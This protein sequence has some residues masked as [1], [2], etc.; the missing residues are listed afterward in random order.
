MAKSLLGAVVF[1]IGVAAPAAADEPL[2]IAY[3]ERPPLYQ[4]EAG[5]PSGTLVNLVVRVLRRAAIDAR[6]EALPSNRIVALVQSG[7][8]PICSPGWFKTPERMAFARFTLPIHRGQASVLLVRKGAAAAIAVH[9]SFAAASSDLRL[10]LGIVDRFS[11][12]RYIDERILGKQANVTAVTGTQAQLA[13][14][15]AA[16]RMDYMIVDPHEIAYLMREAA[17]E[18][19]GLRT[20]TFPDLPVGPDR[21]VM[22]S[23]QVDASVLRR[24]DAAIAA[25]APTDEHTERTD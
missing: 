18:P 8:K 16:G 22:C 17:I 9:P 11:F 24:M 6:W 7:G 23:A 5:A 1:L 14:M 10:R 13:R 20:H 21:H 2:T 15:V 4:T 25:I 19:D 12:G 3:F